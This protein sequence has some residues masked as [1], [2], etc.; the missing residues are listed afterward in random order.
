MTPAAVSYG[1]AVDVPLLT[2]R[3][4]P[5]SAPWQTRV[6]GWL[7]RRRRLSALVPVLVVLLGTPHACPF[8]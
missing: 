3:P 1:G 4:A 7:D 8:C 5:R 2:D 6:V